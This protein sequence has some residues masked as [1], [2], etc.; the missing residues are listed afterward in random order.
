MDTIT[1]VLKAQ[2]WVKPAVQAA[3]HGNNMTYM[4]ICSFYHVV[5]H[6]PALKPNRTQVAHPDRLLRVLWLDLPQ[7]V[8]GVLQA[9]VEAGGEAGKK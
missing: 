5:S 4:C 9:G 1:Q 2:G 8:Q 7:P 6:E 3:G